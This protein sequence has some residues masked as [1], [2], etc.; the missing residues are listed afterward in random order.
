MGES[1]A[2]AIVLA[3]GSG[4]RLG[5]DLPKAL[6]KVA[7]VPMVTRAV[8][9]ATAVADLVVVA[10]PAGREESVRRAL[11]RSPEVLVVAGGGTRQASVRAALERIP[12]DREL[13][14]VHDAARPFASPGLFESVIAAVVAGVD[15]VVPVVAISDTIKR[16][17]GGTVVATEDR[18]ELGL[19]QT[20]Q[21][22]RA[23]VLRKVHA[24]ADAAGVD[25]TDDAAVLE[26][27]GYRVSVVPGE[28]GNFKITT[29]ADLEKAVT[30]G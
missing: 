17:R 13:I 24:E 10:A 25:L 30:H 6:V 19:A 2:A 27:A 21:A 14:V 5:S 16:V 9:A 8:R 26:W 29:P 12:T 23:S 15:G 3:G 18:T 11:D 28:P 1:R 20:P 22:F 4:S 7:G